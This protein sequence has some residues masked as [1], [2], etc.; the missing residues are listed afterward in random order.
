MDFS[1]LCSFSAVI[2]TIT[3]FLIVSRSM[4]FFFFFLIF[5]FFPAPFNFTLHCFPPQVHGH[6]PLSSGCKHEQAP[7]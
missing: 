5:D 2:G 3:D 7:W 4:I 1:S 6:W